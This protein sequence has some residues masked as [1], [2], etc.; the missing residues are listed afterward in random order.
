MYGLSFEDRVLRPAPTA[1]RGDVAFAVGWCA[2]RADAR[3]SPQLARWIEDALVRRVAAGTPLPIDVPLPFDSWADFEAA[4]DWRNRAV[5]RDGGERADATLGVAVRD[6]FANGG[7]RIYVSALGTPWP[8]TQPP[9]DPSDPEAPSARDAAFEQI[10]ARF[11]D[12]DRDSW[13]GLAPLRA[14]DDVAMVLVPD[15]A[16]ISASRTERLAPSR[17]EPDPAEVFVECATRLEPRGGD[18]GVLRIPVPRCDDEDYARWR[19]YAARIGGFLAQYRRD[20]CAVLALP[21]PARQARSGRDALAA[22]DGLHSSFLQIVYPWLKPVFPPRVAQGLVAPDGAA[23]GLIAATALRD[24]AWRTAAGRT[25]AQI[26]DLEPLPP[27]EQ[28]RTPSSASE[29]AAAW[30]SRLS[31]FAPRIDRIELLSDRTLSDRSGWR[32]ASVGRLMGQLLR[33]AR[34]EGEAFAFEAASDA[35]FARVR[36]RFEDLLTALWQQQ[37]LCGARPGDAFAVRCD[38]R[39]MTQADLDN[40]RV[41]CAIE[42]TPAYS[43]ERIRVE[44]ALGESGTVV[45]RETDAVREAAA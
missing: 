23:A 39:L 4:A 42:F 10:V 32:N 15:L 30:T 45:W 35:L 19:G 37:A 29:E 1:P 9:A 14:L 7:R 36:S 12:R 38:R 3:V 24:G 26:Y 31:L 2:W 40:G 22:I 6:F 25:P 44:L 5:A 13:R 16:E 27:P 43:L 20:C 8:L 28:L 21:L 18:A 34:A 33:F 17:D 11:V 41:V